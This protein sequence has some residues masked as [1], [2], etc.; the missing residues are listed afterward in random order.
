MVSVTSSR[1]IKRIGDMGAGTLLAWAASVMI[2]TAAVY[3]SL[4]PD[5]SGAFLGLQLLQGSYGFTLDPGV[6]G[7]G[8]NGFFSIYPPVYYLFNAGVFAITGFGVVQA[9]T[10]TILFMMAAAGLLF[11]VARRRA[12]IAAGVL[13]L[14]VFFHLVPVRIYP[15]IV[16]RPDIAANF[17]IF[18]SVALLAPSQQPGRRI[19]FAFAGAAYALA[20]LS[21][22]VALIAAPVI[23][24]AVLWRLRGRILRDPRLGT[25]VGGFA[26]P[27][28]CY[29]AAAGP[30]MMEVLTNLTSYHP[31]ATRDIAPWRLH[32]SVLREHFPHL[33]ALLCGMALLAA[34]GVIRPV[35]DAV[36][37]AAVYFA[38]VSVG[39]AVAVSFYPNIGLL[40][41]YG[42]SYVYC[43]IIG[44]A[45]SA[46]TLLQ[47]VR[48]NQAM[49]LVA[50]LVILA[51]RV[52]IFH[53][54]NIGNR[55]S[56]QGIPISEVFDWIGSF[57]EARGPVL[58]PL[59]MA[60][61][62]G[63]GRLLDAGR[64]VNRDGEIDFPINIGGAPRAADFGAIVLDHFKSFTDA[65]TM[66][67][68]N[69]LWHAGASPPDRSAS[70]ASLLV[71]RDYQKLGEIIDPGHITGNLALYGRRSEGSHHSD[72]AYAVATPSGVVSLSSPRNCRRMLLPGAP[73]APLPGGE[74]W[75]LELPLSWAGEVSA[76]VRF[77]VRWSDGAP[78]TLAAYYDGAETATAR[79]ADIIRN[80]RYSLSHGSALEKI[81]FAG[82]SLPDGGVGAD[83]LLGAPASGDGRVML[84]AVSPTNIAQIEIAVMVPA[85][86]PCGPREE[87]LADQ[88]AVTMTGALAR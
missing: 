11:V 56:T 42:L 85:D 77:R 73:L 14:A 41:F 88:L 69:R 44:F 36:S 26:A 74:L 40:W 52:L 79:R 50:C 6:P 64:L 29:A 27:M 22:F 18:L 30:H 66:L 32:I 3:P 10:V 20:I 35:R 33:L 28:L 65:D 13:G 2:T 54:A 9:R 38:L 25:F 12:G 87:A 23:A 53:A 46:A 8:N 70:A 86:Q 17:F 51:N 4:N 47:R 39:L 82:H 55:A 1:W 61:S 21:H 80:A 84:Y 58:G 75:G 68:A 67:A 78:Q 72:P 81:T 34:A 71:Q 15:W 60:F 83:L 62:S 43:A 19:H 5:E 76:P 24:S 45:L 48:M 37:S 31:A 57:S 7:S 16:N 49:I 59:T 63:H